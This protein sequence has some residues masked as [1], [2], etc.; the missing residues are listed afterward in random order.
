[1]FSLNILIFTIFYDKSYVTHCLYNISY[2]YKFVVFY[3]AYK[4]LLIG[5]LLEH[6]FSKF[7]AVAFHCSQNLLEFSV[8]GG[9]ERL[10]LPHPGC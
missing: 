8:L 1:M 5:Y 2:L 4:I 7:S 3:V 9:R 6:A 10:Y